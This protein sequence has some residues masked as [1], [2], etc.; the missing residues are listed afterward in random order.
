MPAVNQKP[1]T[2]AATGVETT[3]F[4]PGN[5]AARTKNKAGDPLPKAP[6][7]G[8][9]NAAHEAEFAFQIALANKVLDKHRNLLH[10]LADR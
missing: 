2:R 4:R 6:D 3:P 7:G 9:A 5:D 1:R 10:M 8:D